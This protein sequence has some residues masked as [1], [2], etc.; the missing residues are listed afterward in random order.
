MTRQ[1]CTLFDQNYV[2][3]AVALHRSL[4]RHCPSFELTAF[5]FDDEA[6]RIV[7]ALELPHVSTV[8][9]EELE[10]FDASSSP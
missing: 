7:D 10:A 3:K 5:C 2:F 9:L 6:R 8:S 4:V 1:F